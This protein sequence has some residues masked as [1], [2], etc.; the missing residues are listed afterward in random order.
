M[1]DNMLVTSTINAIAVSHTILYAHTLF[2]RGDMPLKTRGP[3]IVMCGSHLIQ[4][5]TMMFYEDSSLTRNCT[6]LVVIG[7]LFGEV[8]FR[9]CLLYMLTVLLTAVT[10]DSLTSKIASWTCLS[11]YIASSIVFME[12]MITSPISD[13]SYCGQVLT[14]WKT[15]VNN[16][17]FLASFLSVGLPIIHFLYG[18]V[19]KARKT[20]TANKPSLVTTV[21]KRQLWFLSGFTIVYVG[22]LIAQWFIVSWPWLLLDFIV[23][24]YAWLNGISIWSSSP[25][26]TAPVPTDNGNG[27]TSRGQ[28]SGK[29]AASTRLLQ[30]ISPIAPSDAV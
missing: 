2:S 24:D 27:T 11:L 28:R 26:T 23:S 12:H 15:T 10:H 13:E 20:L 9:G 5:I 18:A 16:A 14:E 30:P 21:Y 7:N 8:L 3:L 17:L 29:A 22:L 19:S 1:S 4:R 25:P 6:A